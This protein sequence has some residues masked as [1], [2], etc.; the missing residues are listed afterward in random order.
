MG[1][2]IRMP[3]IFVNV[4]ISFIEKQWKDN[5]AVLSVDYTVSFT[6]VTAY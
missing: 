5:F 1:R 4:P 3:Y 2:F 6:S